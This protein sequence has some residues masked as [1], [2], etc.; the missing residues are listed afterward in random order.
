M[1]DAR[2][3]A[4]FPWNGKFS[5]R[6]DHLRPGTLLGVACGGC[7]HLAEIPADLIRRRYPYHLP[8][9]EL[10]RKFRCRQCGVRGRV[11]LYVGAA[12]GR[13]LS[14]ESSFP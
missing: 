9:R 12:I 14:A 5:A 4:P 8:V 10:P 3:D 13:G 7:G 2:D 11:T 1:P 6:V